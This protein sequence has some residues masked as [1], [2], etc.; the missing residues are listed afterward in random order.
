MFWSGALPQLTPVDVICI[1]LGLLVTYTL[2]T[3]RYF[4]CF[5]DQGVPGPRP[6]PVIGNLGLIASKGKLCA[7]LHFVQKYGNVVGY[8]MGSRPCILVADHD[9]LKTIMVKDF[10]NFQNGRKFSDTSRSLT[11]SLLL[12]RDEHWKYVRSLLA[13]TFSSA[14][15]KQM[16]SHINACSKLLMR[17]LEAQVD[18]KQ[19]FIVTKFTGAFT[20]DVIARTVFSLEVDS[21]VDPSNP[22]VVHASRAFTNVSLANPIIFLATV[23]PVLPALF[24]LLNLS[25]IPRSTEEFFNSVV[26]EAIKGRKGRE[27]ERVDFLQLMMNASREDKSGTHDGER[28]AEE[29]GAGELREETQDGSRSDYRGRGLTPYEVLG[30]AMLFFLAGYDTT[31]TTLTY[32]MYNLA[33]HP[34]CQQKAADEVDRVVGDQDEVSYEMLSKLTYLD[35][36]IQETL[37]M[38]PPSIGMDREVKCDI[39]VNGVI[40]PENAIVTIPIYALHHDPEVWPE[41]DKFDPE[42]FTAEAKASRN[43]FA[44][45]P[46]GHGPRNCIGM[47]LAQQEM[48]MV[49]MSVLRQLRITTCH[50]TQSPLT[51]QKTMLLVPETDIILAV[52]RR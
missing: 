44:Y 11:N 43:P 27:T 39:I 16:T 48:K 34:D 14:K 26:T 4:G 47:R 51:F 24:R 20:M 35:M 33:R 30:N 7:H 19:G 10:A 42:R 22:F 46:F 23:F 2:Y 28:E 8:F 17:N 36:C 50:Q 12:L 6:W 15:L 31:S 38:Y 9:M 1:L 29:E 5:K 52:E 18:N 13:P 32:L 3:T 45:M 40:L 37:R 21:Q 25:V 49:M 41:P